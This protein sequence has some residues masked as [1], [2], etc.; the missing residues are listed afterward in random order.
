MTIFSKIEICYK[1]NRVNLPRVHFYQ[2][3]LNPPSIS[4][5]S[6]LGLCVSHQLQH[7]WEGL[8][9]P[10]TLLLVNVECIC[11][12]SQLMFQVGF[13]MDQSLECIFRIS[14]PLLKG[15]DCVINF[16]YFINKPGW[17]KAR[18]DDLANS[19]FHNSGQSS[20]HFWMAFNTRQANG[21]WLV[22]TPMISCRAYSS[23]CCHVLRR[24]AKYLGFFSAG[25]KACHFP[26]NLVKK[27]RKSP[28]DRQHHLERKKRWK[29]V[30][31]CSHFGILV[32][33]GFTFLCQLM[34][35]G[36]NPAEFPD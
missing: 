6:D 11:F 17:N 20:A 15:L 8:S 30:V 35:I 12:D 25:K 5:R 10:H 18:K 2:S 32:S 36:K 19:T 13:G 28:Y 21:I 14:Q 7:V 33:L 22:Q 4:W 26:M 24:L 16:I 1:C 9:H 31:S 23:A 29:V 27:K 3:I 34:W